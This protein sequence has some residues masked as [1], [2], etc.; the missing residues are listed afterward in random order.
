MYGK[1]TLCLFGT[2]GKRENLSFFDF[3]RGENNA[4]YNWIWTLSSIYDGAFMR[5]VSVVN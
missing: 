4:F 5:T 1:R 2:K 3:F